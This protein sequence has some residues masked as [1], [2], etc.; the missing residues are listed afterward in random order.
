MTP[1]D[2]EIYRKHAHLGDGGDTMEAVDEKVHEIIK[3][4]G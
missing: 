3:V 1:G 2:D 4:W